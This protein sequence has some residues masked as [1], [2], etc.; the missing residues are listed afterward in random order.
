MK[1][2]SR[3]QADRASAFAARRAVYRIAVL[4]GE[5]ELLYRLATVEPSPSPFRY[6]SRKAITAV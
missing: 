1:R 2:P 4:A 5:R 3:R 6:L